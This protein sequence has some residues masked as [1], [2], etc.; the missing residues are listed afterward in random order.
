MSCYHHLTIVE[1]EKLYGFLQ[2]GLSI[3]R[4]AEQL[5][6]SPSTVSREL[7]RNH[8]YLPIHA[9]EAYRRR[10]K[11]CGRKCLLTDV[12][13]EGTVRFFLGHLYWSPEQISHRLKKEGCRSVSTS[14]IYRALDRGILRNTLRYY[15]RF[16]SKT[17]GKAKSPKGGVLS[18]R[19]MNAQARQMTDQSA[20]IG[21]ETRL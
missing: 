13:L 6:R 10:R 4:I 18:G 14:T 3:R 2:K 21:K 8:S 20:G 17:P 1:R 9:Q 19:L 15:L 5:G 12:Q 7:K 16:K 11:N